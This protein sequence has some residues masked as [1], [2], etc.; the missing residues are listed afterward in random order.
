MNSGTVF[1]L[2]G[3][4]AVAFI[5]KQLEASET[6]QALFRALQDEGLTPNVQ[7]S[8]LYGIYSRESR[9]SISVG[10]LPFVTE[11]CTPLLWGHQRLRGGFAR[12]VC[13]ACSGPY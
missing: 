13:S 11:D 4:D 12:A 5:E 1:Q 8:Q 3:D 7:R 9:K 10:I 2:D 6:A